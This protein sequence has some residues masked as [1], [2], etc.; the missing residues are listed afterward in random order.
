MAYVHV[1]SLHDQVISIS[2]HNYLTSLDMTAPTKKGKLEEKELKEYLKNM[3]AGTAMKLCKAMD[4]AGTRGSS[5]P[6]WI[7]GVVLLSISDLLKQNIYQGP[8]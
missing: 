5:L 3:D 8:R 2:V 7:G 6:A 1:S 4:A